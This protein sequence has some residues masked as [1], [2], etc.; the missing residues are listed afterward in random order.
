MQSARNLCDNCVFPPQ[1]NNES[2]HLRRSEKDEPRVSEPSHDTQFCIS[3]F[4][5]WEKKK[6]EIESLHQ[7]RHSILT[8]Q[9]YLS[10]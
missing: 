9:L 7:T 10:L 8:K 5:V 6:V 3:I 4:I 2:K 1:Q